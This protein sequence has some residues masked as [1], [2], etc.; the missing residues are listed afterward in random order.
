MNPISAPVG[1]RPLRDVELSDTDLAA[2]RQGKAQ[3]LLGNTIV[4]T[5]EMF[6]QK[7]LDVTAASET[8]DAFQSVDKPLPFA[9][10]VLA[11][12]LLLLLARPFWKGALL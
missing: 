6:R 3:A 4:L 7:R 12:T 2:L 11:G 8:A 9:V 1:G 10:A 5:L